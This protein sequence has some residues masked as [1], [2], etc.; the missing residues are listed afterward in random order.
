MNTNT[1][2][3]RIDKN[4]IF[5]QIAKK[6]SYIGSKIKDE[7]AYDN[8]F[9]TDE[10]NEFFEEH[11]ELAHAECVEMLYPYTKKDITENEEV[12]D[13]KNMEDSE[14]P[15][16]SYDIVLVIPKEMSQTT[17]SLVERQ[18]NEYIVSRLIAE[19]MMVSDMNLH[20]Y[21]IER[22]TSIRRH[23]NTTLISRMKPLRRTSRPF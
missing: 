1:A 9:T 18:I 7:D 6:T 5:E 11:F 15:S 23:I 13:G 2:T 21:W 22:Y 19:W 8:I 20:A 17:I 4:S 10:D 16:V 12:Q 3:I 14:I